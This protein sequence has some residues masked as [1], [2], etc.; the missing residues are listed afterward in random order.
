MLPNINI[1]IRYNFLFSHSTN[2]DTFIIYR[3]FH[4]CRKTKTKQ[5]PEEQKHKHV[6]IPAV[7]M[8]T[9][10]QHRHGL[11]RRRYRICYH[12]ID[13]SSIM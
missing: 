13:I 6:M 5:S 11:S 4:D 7:T 2:D 9:D 3:E 10:T 1:Y 8:T 12:G